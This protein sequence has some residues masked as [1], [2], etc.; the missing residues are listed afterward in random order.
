MPGRATAN[1]DKRALIIGVSNYQPPTVPTL[2]GAGDAAPTPDLP[3]Q[4]DW[5]P[6]QT[7]TPIQS[8]T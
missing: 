6:T 3:L 1:A 4:G 8:K 2:G 7:P 5:P